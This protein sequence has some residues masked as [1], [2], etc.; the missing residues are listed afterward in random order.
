MSAMLR[1]SA[2]SAAVNAL[3]SVRVRPRGWTQR[4][5]RGLTRWAW[6]NSQRQEPYCLDILDHSQRDRASGQKWQVVHGCRRPPWDVGLSPATSATSLLVASI[7]GHYETAV[8][9]RRKEHGALWRGYTLH[10]GTTSS[11]PARCLTL[12]PFS[13]RSGC[14]SPIRSRNPIADQHAG[15]YVPGLYT[16][17]VINTRVC[18]TQ[19]A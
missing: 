12:K 11:E 5:W 6:P 16:P 13:V 2:F 7:A 19:S 9:N 10:D 4:N 17:P 1:V 8:I 14:N 18:N 15:E 3:H